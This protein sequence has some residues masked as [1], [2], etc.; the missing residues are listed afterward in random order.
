MTQQE[1]FKRYS[2]NPK[3]D[4]LGAGGF[5]KVFRAYDNVLDKYV[6]I[7]IS[8]VGCDDRFRLK[9]EVE[10]VTSL[11]QHPNI[12]YYEAVY[13][14]ELLDGEADFGILQYYEE[15]NLANLLRRQ[16]LSQGQTHQILVQLLEG[17]Q[18]LH[19]NGVIHRDLKPENVL[20]VNRRGGYIP[21]IT[22]FGISKRYDTLQ[23]SVS[24]TIIGGSAGFACPEQ[25]QTSSKIRPNADLWSVG[26]MAYW[27]FTG[28]MPFDSYAAL[29]DKDAHADLLTAIENHSN[30]PPEYKQLIKK[31]LVYNPEE[32]IK[33]AEQCL[34]LI[35][36][37]K[38]D[39][40]LEKEVNGDNQ[41][42][43]S[44]KSKKT[45]DNRFLDTVLI[46]NLHEEPIKNYTFNILFKEDFTVHYCEECGY[47]LSK[48]D[49][50][51]KNF[52]SN[53]EVKYIDCPR[54]KRENYIFDRGLTYSG[55]CNNC[56]IPLVCHPSNS[57]RN[58][59]S[60]CGIANRYNFNL[61]K[62]FDDV[63]LRDNITLE[64]FEENCVKIRKE[65]K[66]YAENPDFPLIIS[67]SAFDKIMDVYHKSLE[68]S[69][70]EIPDSKVEEYYNL[71]FQKYFTNK[72]IFFEKYKIAKCTPFYFGWALCHDEYFNR[73]F[74]I[75]SNGQIR[76]KS[77]SKLGEH[78]VLMSDTRCGFMLLGTIDT[79]LIG[80]HPSHVEIIQ[81][82]EVI[83][84]ISKH[85]K[86]FHIGYLDWNNI[87]CFEY[88]NKNIYFTVDDK[89]Y[90]KKIL[91]ETE[92]TKLL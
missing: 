9:S 76:K 5:G 66:F 21:K 53:Y 18:F 87:Y 27:I 39:K 59:C 24:N 13:T 8:K 46:L 38:S 84:L 25:Y 57:I 20:I 70:I 17:L 41:D 16:I 83:P 62:L 55:N 10:L 75:S 31:S 90:E 40:F 35:K 80:Y 34:L 51:I 6:A 12:A 48:R 2:Y 36:N 78:G 23:T 72:Y 85:D 82:G 89:T 71:K 22:D 81:T 69:G 42:I 45:Y 91:D 73:R 44:K 49:V 28:L 1:F 88:Q 14:F 61:I 58:Y 15:G 63:P 67:P 86:Y 56:G 60:N 32:R 50:G 79:S 4:L 64:K 7:K 11:S 37:I 30:I 3:E 43:I 19:S 33:T 52:A 92:I 74:L 47:K 77:N 68:L 54:C 26:V 29:F 65:H